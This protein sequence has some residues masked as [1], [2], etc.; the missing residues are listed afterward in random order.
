MVAKGSGGSV[1]AAATRCASRSLPGVSSETNGRR[2][3]NNAVSGSADG[4]G[5]S[6][7]SVSAIAAGR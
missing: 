2:G 6:P 3:R 4:S 5:T 1:R 7:A